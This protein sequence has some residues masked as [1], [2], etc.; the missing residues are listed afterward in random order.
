MRKKFEA[1]LN[2]LSESLLEMFSYVE[3][4]LKL[5]KEGV[6]EKNLE[7]AAAAIECDDKID[8]KEREIENLCLRIFLRQQ[9]VASDLR[10]VS[11]TLKVIRDLERIGDQS[12][13]I[14]EIILTEKNND[15]I[16]KHERLEKMINVS[17][18]MVSLAI[19][20]YIE[21]NMDTARAVIEM[22]LIVNNLFTEIKKEL[23]M[24]DESGIEESDQVIDLIMISKYLER[25]GDHACNI[26]EWTIFSLT[27][28]YKNDKII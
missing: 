3:N 19:G 14:S 7:S 10:K 11:S 13:D 26:A 8:I 22:D 23:I 1:Q 24:L 25:I 6:L 17:F 5:T 28:E 20:S 12:S 9:P 15:Y 4:S 2:S 21:K 18:E 27:G 16:Q